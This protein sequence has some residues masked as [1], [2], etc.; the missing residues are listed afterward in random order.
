[1]SWRNWIYTKLTAPPINTVVDP[2]AVFAGGSIT[3]SPNER[4]FIIYR[5][6]ANSPRLRDAS[7]PVATSRFAEVWVYDDHGSY[8]RIDSILGTIRGELVGQV[9]SPD[10]TCCEW[11]G[12]SI[13]LADDELNAITR[14]SVFQL[15]GGGS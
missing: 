1:M 13:E 2:A 3:T 8:D 11:I 15:I 12:D 4:P 6:G 5:I 7:N 10:K 9:A 14:N